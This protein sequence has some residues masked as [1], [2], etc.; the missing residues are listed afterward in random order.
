[1]GQAKNRGS[2]EQRIEEA[3]ARQQFDNA[4]HVFINETRSDDVLISRWPCA[5]C[6]KTVSP[7]PDRNE[8]LEAPV[9]H[10]LQYG[11]CPH[12]GTSHLIV[13]AR[14]K[15]DCVKLE[16]VVDELRRSLGAARAS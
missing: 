12:C 7:D 2:R 6:G 8:V 16:P 9:S 3:K 10:G 14:T 15:A 1:M 11:A 4:I 13:S 5:E